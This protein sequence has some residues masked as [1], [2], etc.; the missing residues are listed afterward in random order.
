MKQVL[1]PNSIKSI[2]DI[3]KDGTLCHGSSTLSIEGVVESGSVL[4]EIQ[5][6]TLAGVT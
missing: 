1:E 6:E 4:E 5:N 2:F 3:K